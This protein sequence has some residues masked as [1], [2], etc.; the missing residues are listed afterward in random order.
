MDVPLSPVFKKRR[1]QRRWWWT[2][3]VAAVL[4]LA[5]AGFSRIRPAPPLVERSLVWSDTVRRGDMLRQVPGSGTLVPEVIRWIVAPNAGRVERI[6]VQPGERV[7]A[8]TI[9][10]V[11][12]NPDL[13]QAAFDAESQFK[14]VKAETAHLKAQFASQKLTQQAAVATAEANAVAAKADF[15]V[16][17]ELG[18]S[19]LVAALSVRLSKVKAEQLARLLGIEQDRLKMVEEAAD[20]QLA[21]QLEK[22][23]QLSAQLAL[24]RRQV[25]GLTVRA[26]MDGV[27]QRLGDAAC[28]LQAGQQLPPG[29]LIARVANPERLKAQIKISETQ[30]KDVQLDQVATVDTRNGIVTGHVARIDPAVEGGTVTVDVV[31]DGPLPNGARP[32]LSVEG[33]IELE[34]L[35]SVLQVG[36][37][38]QAQPESQTRLFK[39]VEGGGGAVR[40]PVKLGR[41]SVQAVE[42]LEGLQAGDQ[43]ILSDMSAWEA[44]DR[45]RLR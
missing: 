38:V 33:A 40:V 41:G 15:D 19:G 35:G 44:H 2:S 31:L 16:N 7:K 5:A 14:G 39:L 21:A 8:D 3:A 17:E 11:M 25:E 6:L 18:K 10:V 36:R 32:D 37:P 42:V 23:A 20:A 24:K 1:R 30:A 26:S 34:R 43:V 45:I 9:L 28:P 22:E 29:A 13:Q 27:L 12:A 4:A